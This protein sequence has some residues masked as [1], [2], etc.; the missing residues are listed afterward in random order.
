MDL[1]PVFGTERNAM[2]F[3]RHDASV[4]PTYPLHELAHARAVIAAQPDVGSLLDQR[5]SIGDRCRAAAGMKERMVVLCVA[6]GDDVVRRQPQHSKRHFESGRLVD[7]RRQDH[8]RPLVEYDLMLEPE[9]ANCGENGRPVRVP[10]SD[11]DPTDR[12]RRHPALSQP[13]DE[14]RRRG[15]ANDALPLRVRIVDQRAVLG[16]H[17]VE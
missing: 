9:V 1:A 3:R 6:N 16:D 11:D 5:K 2:A 10:R 8:D 7:T 4:L 12:Q 13:F 15:G 14:R 17:E